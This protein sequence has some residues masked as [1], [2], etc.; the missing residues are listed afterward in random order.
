MRPIVCASEVANKNF[1]EILPTVDVVAGQTVQ[2]SPSRPLQHQRSIAYSHMPAAAGDAGCF[3]VVCQPVLRL[4]RSVILGSVSRE[5][6]SL[7]ESLRP[8]AVSEARRTGC[9]LLFSLLS[10]FQQLD[11]VPGVILV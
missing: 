11:A 9:S 4:C 1:R 6:E 5:G 8:N 7:G 3:H 10:S 2:P